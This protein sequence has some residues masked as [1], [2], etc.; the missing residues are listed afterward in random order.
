V[1]IRST[2]IV[3]GAALMWIL[4]LLLV[5]M[6]APLLD[7]LLALSFTLSL[8]ILLLALYT[9][10]PLDFSV[11]PSLLLIVTLLRLGLNVASTRLILAHGTNG[12]DAA[13]RVIQAFADITI[14]GNYAVGIIL[15]LIFV[16]IN[17]VVIARGSGRIAEVAARFTLDSMPGKQMAIDADLNQGLLDESE[18]KKRRRDLQREAD[19]YGAMDGASK[20]VRG[21][22][23]AGLVIVGVNIVGG[24][25][26]GVLQGGM[27]VGEALETFTALTV[28]EGLVGQVPALIV[29]TAAG[30]V[31]S[32]AA[33]G[34]PLGDELRAQMLIQPRALFGT[35][36]LL[37]ALALAP[38]FPFLPFGLLSAGAGGLAWWSRKGQVAAAK[39]ETKPPAPAVSAESD[40][41]SAIA[42]DDLELEIGYGLIPLVDASRGGDLPA[43][44]RATRRQL[45]AE[46]GFVVPLIHI[47]DNLSLDQSEYAVS[48]RGNRVAN[49]RVPPGRLLAIASDGGRAEGVPGIVVRDPAFGLPAVWIQERDRET[50]E[51]RGFTVVDPAAAIATHLA[52]VVRQH[53]AELLTRRQVRELLDAY[54]EGSPKVVEEIVPGIVSLATLHRTLR[55]LLAEGVSIRDLAAVLE[56]LAEYA[57]KVQQPDLLTDL[58]RERLSRTVTRPH[59]ASSGELSVVTLDPALE[60]ALQAGVQ[61]TQSGSFLAVEPLLLDRLLRGIQSAFGSAPRDG[62]ASVLLSGQSIRAPLRQLLARVLPRVVVLSHNELPPDIR[63]VARGEVRLADAHQAI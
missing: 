42:L 26:I 36:A 52:E 25:A 33:G 57:P 59:L 47:R 23:I 15:F 35:S 62:A 5:P 13:G 28:G 38:G 27:P 39:V 41:K 8:L 46:L 60:Q 34:D 21:D 53:A 43:R 45:A 32:R 54:A 31:V 14:G 6:P 40:L 11:F 10:R 29:S 17:F 61:H 48:V 24:L 1:K 49:S 56:T 4:A 58:V 22:A 3:L 18:A 55:A 37:G 9:E 51:A 63:V 50:A 44:I 16:I 30:I 19:F 2:E 12:H 20:F 7:V